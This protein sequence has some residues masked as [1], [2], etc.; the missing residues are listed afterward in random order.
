MQTTVKVRD[1]FQYSSI[2]ILV[3]LSLILIV[4]LALIVI[5]HKKE[6]KKEIRII[7]PVN[8]NSIKERYIILIDKLMSKVNDG[9][10]TNRK[11]YQELSLIIR[12]FIYEM[13]SIK[14]YNYTLTDIKKLNI[15][16]LSSLVE[17]YYKPEFSYDSKGDIVNS[18]NKTKEVI[19]RWQ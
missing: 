17:E 6:D 10:I 12:K 5:S 11:A 7:E 8:K 14:V 13:T 2:P 16:C 9:S 15:S 1:L 3:T 19:L 18:I 4:I